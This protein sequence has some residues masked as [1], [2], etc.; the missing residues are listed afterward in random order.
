MKRFLIIVILASIFF[1]GV[2]YGRGVEV[3]IEA[4]LDFVE[5]IHEVASWV[6]SAF[7]RHDESEIRRIAESVPKLSG[8]LS[9]LAGEKKALANYLRSYNSDTDKVAFERSYRDKV[10]QLNQKLREIQ[11]TIN[12][13]D[14]KWKGSN[15]MANFNASSAVA[16]KELFLHEYGMLDDLFEVNLTKLAKAY[17]NEA[18]NLL[19]S[20]VEISK[21]LQEHN[22]GVE[23]DA[24]R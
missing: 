13:M 24:S 5:L 15:P 16:Q 23:E 17:N 1:G 6:K 20:S 12:E 2:S 18:V 21:T 9:G 3:Q 11:R 4:S 14:P 22:N 10:R 19:R 8:Q 7:S